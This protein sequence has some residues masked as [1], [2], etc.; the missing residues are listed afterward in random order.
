MKTLAFY[1]NDHD[2]V[3]FDHIFFFHSTFFWIQHSMNWLVFLAAITHSKGWLW[4][5]CKTLCSIQTFWR[6]DQIDCQPPSSPPDRMLK[7]SRFPSWPLTSG[8]LSVWP[9]GRILILRNPKLSLREEIHS[10]LRSSSICDLLT[11]FM[12]FPVENISLIHINAAHRGRR[13]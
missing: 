4:L 2:S 10:Q 1:L 9:S 8:R 5:W 12:T 3:R 13:L 11:F 7:E 6:T